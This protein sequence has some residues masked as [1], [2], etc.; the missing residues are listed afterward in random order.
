MEIIKILPWKMLMCTFMIF[1]S[2]ASQEKNA[3]NLLWSYKDR[4]VK[5]I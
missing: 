1:I 2:I 3:S 5:R 4:L